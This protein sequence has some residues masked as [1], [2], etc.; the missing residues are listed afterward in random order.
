MKIL[1][2][3]GIYPPDIGGP[4]HYAKSLHDEFVKLEHT[5]KV[6][7]YKI[8]KK[9]PIGVRHFWFFVKTTFSLRGV[10][11]II[12]LDTFSVGLPAVLAG[13]LFGKKVIIRTGGDFLWELYVA[14][15]GYKILLSEFYKK[16]RKYSIKEKIIFKLTRFLLQNSDAVVF[17]TDWQRGIFIDAYELNKEKTFII[18][19]FYG[20]KLKN[21]EPKEKNFLWSGRDI[22]LKNLDMLK[23]AF[24]EARKVDNSINLDIVDK[25]PRNELLEKIKKCYTIILP[26]MSEVSPNF[27]LEALM[28]NKPFITTKDTGL[29]DKLKNVGNFVDPLDTEDVKEKILFLA[30]DYNYKNAKNKVS[31]FNF[32]H[33]YKEISE[34]LLDVYKNIS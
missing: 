23:K 25:V 7:S 24:K 6:L 1:I 19:N 26:S 16:E 10:N 22:P 30:D 4:A 28:L 11:F 9:L 31:S 2:A 12:A 34:E 3:T 8:E 13:K 5:V 32:T 15:T 14:R 33:S 20:E 29:Y 21:V 27:V 17:S 18:E